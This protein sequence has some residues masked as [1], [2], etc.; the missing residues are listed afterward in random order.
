MRLSFSSWKNWRILPQIIVIAALPALAMF[1]AMLVFSF[2]SRGQEVA[3]ETNEKGAI[4]AALVAALSEYAV[5]SGDLIYLNPIIKTLLESDPS[6]IGLRITDAQGVTLIEQGSNPDGKNRNTLTFSAPIIRQT[7][8]L[9][10]LTDL[11]S[12]VRPAHA[13]IGQVIL[14]VNE[15]PLLK[16]Q[17][18]RVFVGAVIATLAFIIALLLGTWLAKRITKP[19]TALTTS[20]GQIHAGQYELPRTGAVGGEVGRL[21]HA[22]AAMAETVTESRL[23]LERKV[24]ARTAELRRILDK[25]QHVIEEER[26]YISRE[27]HD[28]L[29]AQLIVIR[30]EAQQILS[31]LPHDPAPSNMDEIHSHVT[32]ITTRVSDLYTVA[33]GIVRRLRPEILETLG[34]QSALEEIVKSYD[35]M[36]SGCSFEWEHE[37]DFSTLDDEVAIAAYRSVQEGLSNI[38]R[39]AQAKCAV[40]RL[41]KREHALFIIIKDDGQ[42]LKP[43]AATVGVGLIGM[44]ER[45]QALHGTFRIISS[46]GNGT[47]LAMKFPIVSP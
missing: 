31:L 17:R 14:L 34:L 12:Q 6:V 26:R 1:V 13:S 39:H 3:E 28:H 16:K 7:L 20:V 8:P 47:I 43:G 23:E 33:R 15:E 24:E 35:E 4:T 37:G 29:N 38:V 22:I 5:I 19:L 27:L 32:A 10:E 9:S 21:Q 45:L 25:T 42:G 11:G 46:P 44:R 30:L 41:T 2:Y 40:V 18:H 36:Q